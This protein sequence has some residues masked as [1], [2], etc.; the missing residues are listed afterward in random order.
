MQKVNNEKVMENRMFLVYVLPCAKGFNLKL[1]LAEHFGTCFYYNRF[2]ISTFA[3][4]EP[5]RARNV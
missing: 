1:Y 5:K 2:K 4:F 3:N